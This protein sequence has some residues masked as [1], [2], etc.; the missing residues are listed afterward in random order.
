MRWKFNLKWWIID[1]MMAKCASI[2]V[3]DIGYPAL[4]GLT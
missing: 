3:A 2:L 4:K 1:C